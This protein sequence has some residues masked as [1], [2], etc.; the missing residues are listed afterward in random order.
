MQRDGN[1]IV[2]NLD[3]L[4]SRGFCFEYK[5]MFCKSFLQ[6]NGFCCYRLYSFGNSW[7]V[8]L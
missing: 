3:D 4:E 5:N 8:I 2:V 7:L 1:W 6:Y